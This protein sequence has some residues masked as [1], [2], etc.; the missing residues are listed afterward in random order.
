[1]NFVNMELSMQVGADNILF[2]LA[3]WMFSCIYLTI[4][5]HVLMFILHVFLVSLCPLVCHHE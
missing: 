2:S 4:P 3:E 1:M 5:V